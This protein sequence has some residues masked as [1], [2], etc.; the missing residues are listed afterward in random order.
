MMRKKFYQRDI[1]PL[2]A[3]NCFMI[4]SSTKYSHVLVRIPYINSKVEN[5]LLTYLINNT[6]INNDIFNIVTLG[7]IYL[8]CSVRK[9]WT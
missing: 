3:E 8:I 4:H 1:E 7:K 5:V 6:L 2:K 9:K